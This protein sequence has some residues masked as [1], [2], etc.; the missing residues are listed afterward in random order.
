MSQL[1]Q[2]PKTEVPE[3]L[4]QIVAHALLVD[5][6]EGM[7]AGRLHHEDHLRLSAG[8]QDILLVLG[9]CQI[10]GDRQQVAL[11]EASSKDLQVLA[12]D[13]PQAHLPLRRLLLHLLITSPPTPRTHFHSSL[14]SN[15]FLMTLVLW[16][17]QSGATSHLFSQQLVEDMA[18]EDMDLDKGTMGEGMLVVCLQCS[19]VHPLTLQTMATG[20]SSLM[21]MGPILW[22]QHV[23]LNH[24][25]Q[26]DWTTDT[27]TVSTTRTLLL[28]SQL[29]VLTREHLW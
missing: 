18:V 23:L 9:K 8:R 16:K 10:T 1:G 24:H 21:A 3:W 4:W 15:Q 5:L 26:M 14:P 19:Q 22:F 7:F 20:T 13:Q 29:P 27:P 2:G 6:R 17:D 12:S 11:V 28:L 25:L